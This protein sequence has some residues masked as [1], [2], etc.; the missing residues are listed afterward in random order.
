MQNDFLSDYE[1]KETIGKGTFSVV[2][3]GINKLT[4]EKVAIKI[5]K[6]NKILHKADKSRLEREISILKKLNHINVIKIHKINEDSEKYYIVMEY[7][8][9]GELFNYI[10][11]KQKLDQDEASYF[12]YQL[13]NGLDYIHHKNIVH[14]DLKPENL[15]LGKGNILKIVDFG[16]SN[17]Y[18]KEKLLSTPCG[19]PCYASPEMVCGNKYNGM[20]IDIWSCGIII[21][22]MTCGYLPFEDI[23]NEMLFKKIMKCKVD[24]PHFLSKNTLDMMKRILVVDPH[25]RISINEIKNHPFYL[26]GK[27]IFESK[28]KNLVSQVESVS[29]EDN[30]CEENKFIQKSKSTNYIENETGNISENKKLNGNYKGI[31]FKK[32]HISINSKD[33]DK[34]K[35]NININVDNNTGVDNIIIAPSNKGETKNNKNNEET[36][37]FIDKKINLT[38]KDIL[39]QNLLLNDL[40]MPPLLD[41]SENNGINPNMIEEYESRNKTNKFNFREK[42]KINFNLL[43]K[44]LNKEKIKISK[45]K[46]I[47]LKTNNNFNKNYNNEEENTNGNHL[48]NRSDKGNNNS[49]LSYNSIKKSDK[50]K[51]KENKIKIENKRHNK[52]DLIKYGISNKDIKDLLFKDNKH[53]KNLYENKTT[54]NKDLNNFEDITGN[55]KE[56][57]NNI[58]IKNLRILNNNNYNSIKNITNINNVKSINNII[59]CNSPLKSILNH[60]QYLTKMNTPMSPNNTNINN[61]LP[62]ISANKN[63]NNILSDF[64]SFRLNKNRNKDVNNSTLPRNNVIIP[65]LKVAKD[66]LDMG[67]PNNYN[68]NETKYNKPPS[69]SKKLFSIRKNVKKN[70]VINLMNNYRNSASSF[71]YMN[72]KALSKK[73]SSERNII[74]YGY[75]FI[76]N[77]EKNNNSMKKKNSNIVFNNSNLN[78]KGSKNNIDPFLYGRN[79]E[80]IVSIK[81]IICHNESNTGVNLGQKNITK[82][83]SN[84]NLVNG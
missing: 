77:L 27:S 42:S 56:N 11:S 15:L 79:K 59:I 70:N 24:Y 21:Y 26:K 8:E 57:N 80:K 33:K 75:D 35:D 48:T 29:G 37:E 20:L 53:M 17:Y 64:N 81:K 49:I 46:K 82:I 39:E 63:R 58:H 66:T 3:L 36:F 84:N 65:K 50:T 32:F 67:V 22:A 30:I 5:L 83:L 4:K 40:S 7:C 61:D 16:L 2:K 19:S 12:F 52:I 6:K 51:E 55:D 74:S 41:I 69:L 47:L 1:I 14:R 31:I 13:I 38:H 73:Q 44:L 34:D 9:N 28:H 10:V 71:D 62:S 18:E 45:E 43:Q 54:K 72:K 25:K 23:S 60:F 68:S 78:K 76:M